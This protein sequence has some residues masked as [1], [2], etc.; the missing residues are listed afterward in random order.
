MTGRGIDQRQAVESLAAIVAAVHVDPFGLV[1][2]RV[3][4]RAERLGG[5]QDPPRVR[6]GLDARGG[7]VGLN[8]N[9]VGSYLLHSPVFSAVARGRFIL[10][11]AA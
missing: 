1:V 11:G 3:L 10:C 7:K 4:G 2:E 8:R 6:G 9:S 5:D